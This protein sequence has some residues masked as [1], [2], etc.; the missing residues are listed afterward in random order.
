MRDE[1]LVHNYSDSNLSMLIPKRLGEGH[2]IF[3][4]LKQTYNANNL[5]Q[6]IPFIYSSLEGGY[7]HVKLK[8]VFSINALL[9]LANTTIALLVL[10]YINGIYQGLL[11]RIE[12]N[13][14]GSGVISNTTDLTKEYDFEIYLNKADHFNLAF[15]HEIFKSIALTISSLDIKI[16]QIADKKLQLP[17]N[18]VTQEQLASILENY[19]RKSSYINP[20]GSVGNQIP[21]AY[22]DIKNVPSQ[23]PP[24][25]HT[26]TELLS[27]IEFNKFKSAIVNYLEVLRKFSHSHDN[28]DV[29]SGFYVEGQILYFKG[30]RFMNYDDYLVLNSEQDIGELLTEIGT[31]HWD[32]LN[33]PPE[34][35][36][37]DMGVN[38]RWIANPAQTFN[39]G[40]WSTLLFNYV[41]V[42]RGDLVYKTSTKWK[43]YPQVPGIYTISFFYV[44]DYG[45]DGLGTGTEYNIRY[46]LFRNGL[47]YS[48]LDYDIGVITGLQPDNNY[49]FR[50]SCQGTDRIVLELGDYIE[51][52][53]KHNLPMAIQPPLSLS[54]G[55]INIDRC[56]T[57]GKEVQAGIIP[58]ALS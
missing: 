49:H 41:E 32:I 28:F 30:R 44:F 50:S 10:K 1:L 35:Y 25:E 19:M 45:N 3:L 11:D 22:Q 13:L 5:L 43:F 4:P 27:E 55:Y 24:R 34:E 38:V 42:I 8:F 21:V 20:D 51:I 17:S 52:K 39:F 56:D 2:D 29:I 46:G 54:Y 18:L 9:D 16:Y 40:A 14:N 48:V 57:Y 53:V 36:F 6:N 26:H 23:F 15:S 7:Y 12:Y 31:I 33:F 58:I 37:F 47:Q